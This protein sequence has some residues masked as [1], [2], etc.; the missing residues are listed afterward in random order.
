MIV[1]DD[2]TDARL[3]SWVP[4]APESDFPIQNLPYGVFSGEG[5]GP[6][7]GVAIGEM[8]LDCRALAEGGLVD[9]CCEPELLLAPIL[10]PLLA[11]G[12]RAWS[13]LRSRLSELLRA[14]GDPALR[15]AGAAHFLFARDAMRMHVPMEIG[16]YVDFYSS[17][18]H[19]TNLGRLFR[20][21]S[22]A[23]LPNWRWIPVGYHGR[24]STIVVDGTPVKRPCGQRKPPESQTPEFGPSRRLDIELEM[25]FVVGPGNR[26][27]EPIAVADASEHIFGLV[28]VNDWSARDVQAW[29]YQPLGPFLG[30]SFATTISPWIV[31]LDALEPFRVDGP[32]QDPQ[33]LPYLQAREPWAY[34]ISLAVELQSARMRERGLAAVKISQTSFRNMYWSVAQQL[35]HATANGAV[36]RAGDLFASGTIS[37]AQPG[38]QGSL[39]ELT[40]NAER[41]IV[42]PDGDVRSFLEDGDEVTLRGWCE[43]RGARRIGFGMAR[44]QIEPA[45]QVV[46]S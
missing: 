39:I 5:R 10:N 17:L 29:E 45:R 18:E 35:A 26:F 44:G 42:L 12:R 34:A 24:S 21:N 23:L 25:G 20:P 36:A 1:L 11:A 40:W 2:T 13:P 14:G 31:T 37:G 41:P 19:A 4:V 30:K 32:Q 28:L 46:S 6:R 3:T 7:I 33:P 38:S 22:E 8:V 15:N 16:D 9:A 27:G 43:R